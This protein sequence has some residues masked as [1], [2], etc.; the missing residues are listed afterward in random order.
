[1]SYKGLVWEPFQ[2]VH[3]HKKDLGPFYF[4]L[5][6]SIFWEPFFK[7]SVRFWEPFFKSSVRFW[8]PFFKSSVRF[9]EPFFKSSVRF[10][11]PFFKRFIF[12]V[13]DMELMLYLVSKLFK[14]IVYCF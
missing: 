1:M 5:L 4:L 9:W 2:K 11:V 8:E 3:C 13:T 10:W 14:A 6:S 12:L 7:S